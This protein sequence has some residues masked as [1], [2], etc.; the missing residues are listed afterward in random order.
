[1]TLFSGSTSTRN[2]DSAR[3]DLLG[4]ELSSQSDERM[5][6]KCPIEVPVWVALVLVL[7]L[8]LE[9]RT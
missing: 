4:N 7:V 8:V 2:S 3:R 5:L 9:L 6:Q 1:M